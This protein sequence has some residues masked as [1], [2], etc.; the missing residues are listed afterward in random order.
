MWFETCALCD[1]PNTA[2]DLRVL[3]CL[4]WGLDE[5]RITYRLGSVLAGLGDQLDT[6]SVW[7]VTEISSSRKAT[8]TFRAAVAAYASFYNRDYRIR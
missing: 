2:G 7:E 8:A 6:R 3:A 1:D 5:T 4:S